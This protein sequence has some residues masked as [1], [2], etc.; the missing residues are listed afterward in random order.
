MKSK[1]TTLLL[2]CAVLFTFEACQNNNSNSANATD[3]SSEN[4]ISANLNSPTIAP[5]FQKLDVPF[6]KMTVKAES[7]GTL[8]LDNGTTIEIP[9]DAFV[10]AN[11]QPVKGDVEI[12]YRE[13]H[14]AAAIV[15]SGIPMTNKTGDKY[16]QTA[17]M[18]EI[19]GEHNDQPIQIAEGKALD[20]NMASY[21]DDGQDYDFFFLDE[22]KG[23]WQT[24]GTAKPTPNAEK[25]KKLK[26]L[27][28]LP[29]KPAKPQA[30]KED[31]F[32]F[33][34][35]INYSKFPELKAYDG[36]IWEYAGTSDASNPQKNKWIFQ[37]DWANINLE[38]AGNGKYQI[39][40]STD[41]KR[42]ASEVKPVLERQKPSKSTI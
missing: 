13:F 17:G 38:K 2:C 40:L 31:K 5:P 15:A 37:E 32:K 8:S 33:N 36:V 11:G 29:E 24:Q 30:R 41:G 6:K 39:V 21:V 1:I 22:D 7:G 25:A 20:V 3:L 12:N 14:D 27:P 23:E 28:A 19:Q 10:D 18:F 26:A 9:K 35:N 4:S 42:F 16:M 34:F